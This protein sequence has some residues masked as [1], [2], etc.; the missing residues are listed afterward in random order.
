M[1]TAHECFSDFN[2]NVRTF[3]IHR[4]HGFNL[5]SVFQV[6]LTSHLVEEVHV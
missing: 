6:R 4:D 3:E 2:T 1:K 5:Q